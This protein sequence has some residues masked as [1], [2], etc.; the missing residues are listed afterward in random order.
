MFGL[1]VMLVPRMGE[2]VTKIQ[3]FGLLVMLVPRMGGFAPVDGYTRSH[4]TPRPLSAV[5]KIH[6]LK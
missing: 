6:R 2:D 4:K 5:Q 1:L 3:M